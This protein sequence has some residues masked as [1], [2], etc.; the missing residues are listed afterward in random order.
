MPAS[1]GEV[2][3]RLYAAAPP[4]GPLPVPAPSGPPSGSAA[5]RAAWHDGVRLTMPG[6]SGR[7]PSAFVRVVP[8]GSTARVVGEIRPT[9]WTQATFALWT[10]IL[11]GSIV[12]SARPLLVVPVVLVVGAV[13]QPLML[14]EV[15]ADRAALRA[16]LTK[17]VTGTR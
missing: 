5:S 16:W 3:Q 9:R 2:T 7:T 12:R 6:G 13:G 1:A 17:T 15:R 14:R 10:V 11:V 4:D 8:E